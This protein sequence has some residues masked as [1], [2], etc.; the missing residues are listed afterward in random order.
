MLDTQQPPIN[1]S[2]SSVSRFISFS[3]IQATTPRHHRQPRLPNCV[4]FLCVESH[5]IRSHEQATPSN[6]CQL[7]LYLAGP[8]GNCNILLYRCPE[9]EE[10]HNFLGHS[11][12][13]AIPPQVSV[14][15]QPGLCL[16]QSRL[17]PGQWI[18]FHERCVSLIL[19][20]CAKHSM[21]RRVRHLLS[22][23]SNHSAGQLCMVQGS[24]PSQPTRSQGCRRSH[25]CNR[26][27]ELSLVCKERCD[28]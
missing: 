12:R 8:Y 7:A 27:G 18:L 16:C 3:H 10:S 24:C 9:L 25:D 26:M 5:Y 13:L 11:K 2:N 1:R 22:L 14:P 28:V 6:C 20:Q 19:S 21:H 4:R 15:P 23:F 17:V